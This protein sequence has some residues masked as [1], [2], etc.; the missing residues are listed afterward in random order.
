[1]TTTEVENFPGFPK[2]VT[3][4]ELMEKMR[5]QSIHC[6]ATIITETISRVDFSSRPFKL[7]VE[8]S[9]G[10]NDTPVL[11]QS[12]ILATGATARR[13]HLPG[14]EKFWNAGMSACAVCDGA[15]PIFRNKAIAVMGGGDTACEEASFLTR[16]ASKVYM[17]VRRDKLRASK[18]MGDRILSNSKIEV[19]W[20]TVPVSFHGERLLNQITIQSTVDSSTRTLDANGFF[21]AIGHTPNTKF[22]AHA[23]SDKLQIK[24][25]DDGY[26]VVKPGTMETSVEGV[27]AAGDVQDRKYRQ[28]VTAAGSGCAAALEAERWLEGQEVEH[29]K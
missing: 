5:E 4:P 1:M 21:Y 13:L 12:V 3:G 19:L 24:V 28:A 27:F 29:R 14:E 7:W 9:D 2:G 22:L 18:V 23:N 10:P 8:G 26:I 6:G 16:Y 25:D 11:T 17:L 15:A 20:N